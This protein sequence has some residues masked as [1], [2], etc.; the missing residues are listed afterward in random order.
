MPATVGIQRFG[1]VLDSRLRG[2]DKDPHPASFA[3]HP[4]VF[5]RDGSSPG[6]ALI[7]ALRAT[8]GSSPGGR[9]FSPR[10]KG[11]LYERAAL[12]SVGSGR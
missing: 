10:E 4:R 2:N 6:G 3:G 12:V 8:P 5:A 1:A 7:R 11:E 9:L